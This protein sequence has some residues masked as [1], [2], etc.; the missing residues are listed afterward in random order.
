MDSNAIIANF[1]QFLGTSCLL[2]ITH[3]LTSPMICCYLLPDWNHCR[4]WNYKGTGDYFSLYRNVVLLP[5]SIQQDRWRGHDGVL[6]EHQLLQDVSALHDSSLFLFLLTVLS[7]SSPRTRTTT[8]FWLP[9]FPATLGRLMMTLTGSWTCQ[10]QWNSRCNGYCD[11]WT[12]TVS[13]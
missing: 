3:L 10:G 6:A 4:K 1:C 8:L 5:F 2:T 13:H 12:V 9:A 11:Y 7:S